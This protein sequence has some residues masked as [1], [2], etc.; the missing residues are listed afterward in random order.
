M[1]DPIVGIDLGTS[2]TVV[3]HARRRRA[4][5]AVLADERRLQDPSVGGVVPPERRRRRRRGGEAAQGHR[6]AEHDLLGQAADRPHVRLARG[7][8]R[9]VARR[10]SR[11]RKAPNQQPLIVTRGGEF[12][13]PEISA[14]VLDHVRNIARDGARQP[15]SRARSSPCRRASTTRSARRPRPPARSPGSPS[16]ACSTSRPR[17]RSRTAT[18]AT[19]SEVIAV[20]D[21]GG[22]TFDI[23]ILKLARPG[24][25]GARHR[26]R[27][28]PRRR[29][30]RRAPRRQDGRRSSSPRTASTCA[31]TRSR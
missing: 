29:R 31:R 24:L 5:C 11:S 7:P 26:R 6:P 19:C 10:R 12:A 25:R 13:V 21:F 2:N 16:C 30:S 14:I 22:G 18:R 9:E 28:V 17:P 27:H 4:R 23:T 1:S 3:A 15:R 8:D 20:Y